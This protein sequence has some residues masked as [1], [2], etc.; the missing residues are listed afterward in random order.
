MEDGLTVQHHEVGLYACT[1]AQQRDGVGVDFAKC[2]GDTGEFACGQRLLRGD[3]AKISRDCA[4]RPRSGRNDLGVHIE[5]LAADFDECGIEVTVDAGARHRADHKARGLSQ[6]SV[7]RA[8]GTIV[9][10]LR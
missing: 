3:A 7:G 9:L 2:T 4:E 1:F 6:R 10:A 8:H 5:R